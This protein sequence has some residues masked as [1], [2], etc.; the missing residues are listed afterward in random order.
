M[1]KDVLYTLLHDCIIQVHLMGHAPTAN[2][3]TGLVSA[4]YMIRTRQYG[5]SQ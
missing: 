5:G 1:E 4:P 2:G 3:L